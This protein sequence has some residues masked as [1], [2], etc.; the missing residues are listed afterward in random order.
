MVDPL[1]GGYPFPYLCGAGVAWKL[2]WALGGEA[3]AMPW[4]D[5]AALAT[6]ADV[7]PL[8]GENRAIVRMGL[9]AIN[10]GHQ[11]PGIA[12]L[13]EAAGLSG[14]PITSTSIAFQLAP[15]LNAGGR[16]GSARRSLKL[17]TAEDPARSPRLA[18][19][20]EDENAGARP[21]SSRSWPR[22]SSSSGTSTSSRIGRSYCPG[23]TG[24]PA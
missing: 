24:I 4:V 14:K 5:I 7:V 6:V 21:W 11:R 2:V 22:R 1:L 17:V 20:L 23:R 3:A 8:T 19:E 15:R 9:D 12:A 13:I 18:E 16:L 10:G